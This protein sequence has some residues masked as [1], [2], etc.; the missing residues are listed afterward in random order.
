MKD[1]FY[2]E[3]DQ[4]PVGQVVYRA[5]RRGPLVVVGPYNPPPLQIHDC[6]DCPHLE[7]VMWENWW[8]VRHT[9]GLVSVAL[10]EWPG[11]LRPNE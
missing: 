8:V 9:E 10:I 2:E 3:T 11:N 6:P 1:G 4:C 7:K 5:G